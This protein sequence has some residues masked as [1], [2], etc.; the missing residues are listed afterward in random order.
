[1]LIIAESAVCLFLANVRQC[2]E[3]SVVTGWH[4]TT[5]REWHGL[6]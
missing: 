5:M 4:V 6:L 1:M 3:M 2:F